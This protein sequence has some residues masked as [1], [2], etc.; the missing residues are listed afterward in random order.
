MHEDEELFGNNSTLLTLLECGAENFII[1]RQWDRKWE[2]SAVTVAKR[3]PY[4]TS[5]F[6]AAT[7]TQRRER[8]NKVARNEAD[9]IWTDVTEGGESETARR[10]NARDRN[11]D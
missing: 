4:G 11:H 2:A 3:R 9:S 8:G 10:V 7:K 5:A 1:E 6:S